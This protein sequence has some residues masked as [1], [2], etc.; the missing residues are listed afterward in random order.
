MN[1]DTITPETIYKVNNIT[2]LRTPL[3]EY[4][5]DEHGILQVVTSSVVID[6]ENLQESYELMKNF[7]GGKKVCMCVD[8]TNSQPYNK[9][10]RLNFEQQLEEF[11]LAVAV[12]SNSRVGSAVANIFIAMTKTKVPMKIVRNKEHAIEWLKYYLS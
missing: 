9:K 11:C 2:T 1:Y 5:F 8:N 7:L 3:A 12:T 6:D 10:Y 4:H